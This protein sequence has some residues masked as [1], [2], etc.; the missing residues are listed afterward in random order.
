MSR[1]LA[2]ALAAGALAGCSG[3][4]VPARSD[5]WIAL[6]PATL[7]RT[8]VAAARIGDSIYVVG[9]FVRRDHATTAAVERYDISENR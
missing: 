1:A 5:R 4:D 7:K 9:G 8:E 3:D 2:V 6:H